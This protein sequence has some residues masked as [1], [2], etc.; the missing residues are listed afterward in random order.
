M[1]KKLT[2]NPRLKFVW[3][4]ISYFA[5]WWDT[6]TN[7]SD[8]EKVRRLIRNGQ[9]EIVMGGWVMN[10]EASSHYFS[11]ISQFHDGHEWVQKN[12]H[13][14]P[15]HGWAIDPFGHSSVMAFLL[16]R[17]G[18][19]AM[20]IQRVHYSVKKYLAQRQLLEFKWRQFHEVAPPSDILCHMMP[21]YSYDIP[22]SCGPGSL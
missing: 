12:L 9:L 7:E 5:A 13:V 19:E 22:H 4:E 21:F 17:M 8:R 2:E 20:L 15:K 11:I 6:L 3:A 16:K 10:D 18:F 14:K 1:L